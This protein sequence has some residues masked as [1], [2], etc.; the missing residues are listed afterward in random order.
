[1]S[2]DKSGT[3]LTELKHLV[4]LTSVGLQDSLKLGLELG[5]A[6]DND[7]LEAAA[8]SETSGMTMRILGSI[9]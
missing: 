1:M 8:S 5:H 9:Q 2:G 7:K 4:T 3:H 6:P